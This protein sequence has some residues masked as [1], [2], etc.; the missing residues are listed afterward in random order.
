MPVLE[1]IAGSREA[2]ST[3]LPGYGEWIAVDEVL[4]RCL[5]NADLAQRVVGRFRDRL[6]DACREL[7]T[8]ATAGDLAA[9]SARAH[10]LKGEAANVGCAR[11]TVLAADVEEF[12]SHRL[13]DG[14]ILAVDLLVSTCHEFQ[15]QAAAQG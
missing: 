9:V 4:D 10:R 6:G 13:H 11:I 15:Q 1:L 14:L 12:A 5:G 7:Q 2:P 8:L 3:A